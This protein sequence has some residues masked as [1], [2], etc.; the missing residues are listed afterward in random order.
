MPIRLRLVCAG[1]IAGSALMLVPEPGAQLMG[2]LILSLLMFG[3]GFAAGLLVGLEGRERK[4]AA[5][6][7]P[8]RVL[9]HP[10]SP[11][12]SATPY[13]AGAVVTTSTESAGSSPPSRAAC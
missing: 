2:T 5:P 3:V 1:A 11:P 9:R 6:A 10:A 8:A 12:V 4:T 7:G 13:P